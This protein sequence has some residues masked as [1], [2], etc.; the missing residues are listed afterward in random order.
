[1]NADN[2]LAKLQGRN[3]EILSTDPMNDTAQFKPVYT[4]AQKSEMSIHVQGH[5][6]DPVHT[7][8]GWNKPTGGKFGF[9]NMLGILG[10]TTVHNCYGVGTERCKDKNLLNDGL[11]KWRTV[12]KPQT[13][14]IDNGF[15]NF[16]EDEQ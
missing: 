4:E 3:D 14:N 7:I 2:K 5:A 15:S 10:K 6:A 12:Y 8:V 13:S 11:L 16:Q 1:N 9:K